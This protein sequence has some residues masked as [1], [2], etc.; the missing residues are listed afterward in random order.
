MKQATRLLERTLPKMIELE[1][2]LTEDLP[3]VEVDPG[4][5]T[6]V[7]VNLA[8]NGSEA[9]PDG[10][11]LTIGTR[12]SVPRKSPITGMSAGDY[13]E[14]YVTDRGIGMDE[15]TVERIFEP[16]YSGKGLAYKTGLGLAVVHGLVQSNGGRIHC[17]SKPGQGTTFR[18]YLPA[19]AQALTPVSAAA[20]PYIADGKETILLVDD[21]ELVRELGTRFLTRMGYTV[22]VAQ[23]GGEALTFYEQ[24]QTEISLIILD[25]I[26]PKM[27]GEQCLER[28]RQINPRVKVVIASG[29]S[30]AKKSEELIAAGARGFVSKPFGHAELSK[31]VR[32][33]LEAS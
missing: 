9:M 7:I 17:D 25:L 16:F 31:A 29:H 3:A 10:G 15:M 23:D 11:T 12:N 32:Q 2:D 33:A 8:L 28:L 14:L 1:T 4:Q 18:V 26:M 30:E 6:Q 21:E 27:G 24:K 20:G 13:V 22:I 5:L 19:L